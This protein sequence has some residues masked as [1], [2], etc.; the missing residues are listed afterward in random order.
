[1]IEW[2][3]KY[4]IKILIVTGLICLVFIII[5]IVVNIIIG[6]DFN[7]TPFKL[8]GSTSDWHNFLSVYLGAL[9]GA[10]VP[11]IILYKTLQ[12]NTIENKQNR[13]TQIMLIKHQS[14]SD[15]LQNFKKSATALCDSFC[16]NKLVKIC[17]LFILD[18]IMPLDLIQQ[19]FSELIVAK[20]NFLMD[21][22]PNPVMV[23]LLD[24]E[25]R[26]YDYYAEILLDFEVIVSYYKLSVDTIK[27][28]ITDDSHASGTLKEIILKNITELNDDNAKK[29]LNK[30]LQKRL[31][32]VDSNMTEKIWD[33]ISQVYISQKTKIVDYL[34][35]A[36]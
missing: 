1:M 34:N 16:Y 13:S 29:W 22:I 15:D 27:S 8:H 20:R 33:L 11:F 26:L 24:E 28:D 32:V 9:I 2:V 23:A 6:S 12:N 5:P 21:A 4:W 18:D 7:P 36:K 14:E 25:K 17:N 10:T 30:V 35:H 3:K 19:G 31:E